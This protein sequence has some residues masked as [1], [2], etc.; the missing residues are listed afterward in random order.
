M[1]MRFRALQEGKL[2]PAMNLAAVRA[3]SCAETVGKSHVK[4]TYTV[5]NKSIK[6]AI[7]VIQMQDGAILKVA[8]KRLSAGHY[9]TKKRKKGIFVSVKKGSGGVVPRSFAWSNTFWQRE[10]GEPREP[11]DKIMSPSVPQLFGNKEVLKEMAKEA[12]K[13]YEERL[14]HEVGRIMG[15]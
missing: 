15:G 7:R 14:R 10:E 3:A 2:R 4:K 5:D 8:G 6:R 13:K 1:K 12:M 9:K 11:F